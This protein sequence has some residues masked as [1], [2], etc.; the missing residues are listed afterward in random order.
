LATETVCN[1]AA[2]LRRIVALS[3]I[4]MSASLI[5]VAPRQDRTPAKLLIV[6]F[7]N[8]AEAEHKFA[9]GEDENYH[10]QRY[11]VD[12][13][14]S[15]VRAGY[16][17]R[18]V[19][20]GEHVPLERLPSGVESVGIR[21]Y[22]GRFRSPRIQS[23]VRMTAQWKPTHLLLQVPIPELLRWAVLN[24]IE[25]L[26]L[27]ADSFRAS[28]IRNRLWYRRLSTALNQSAIRWVVNHGP[29]ACDDLARIGVDRSKLLPF[30]WPSFDSPSKWPAKKAPVDASAI[31]L[32]Y[33]G[34]IAASKGVGDLIE[35][36]AIAKSKGEHYKANLAGSGEIESFRGHS[37]RRGVANLVNFLG[38]VSRGR[39]LELMNIGD[40]VVV[41]SRHEYPEGMPQTIYEGLVSRS[42]VV[43]SDHPM[44]S[45][46]IVPPQNGMIFRA[47]DPHSL[48]RTVHD[49]VHDT[50]L[51]EQ[52]SRDADLNARNFHGPLKWDQVIDR[53]LS[54]TDEDH[55]WL[56][57]YALS[58]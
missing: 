23:L 8:Y 28:G 22:P 30:D 27:L 34:K 29:N 39:V 41:A 31:T 56:G 26:P 53:W 7:G 49:L 6:Q 40:V 24:Q 32:T 25:T 55:A 18:V 13:V 50:A 48:Y 35:A 37:Y 58:R 10:A 43:V 17:V 9:R 45:G 42:P 44:F 4:H 16:Q 5:N 36:I 57:Q 19:S 51:Y 20:L 14:A 3:Q 47:A 54:G 11:S 12:Y 52:L 33:V 21:L 15:L 38:P 2:A 46:R 1:T